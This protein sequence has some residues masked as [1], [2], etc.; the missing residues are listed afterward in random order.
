MRRVAEQLAQVLRSGSDRDAGDPH[1]RHHRL[2]GRQ[3]AELEEL[4]QHLAALGAQRA[5]LLRLFGDELQFLGGVVL[6]RVVLVG[7][8]AERLQN[9]AADAVQHDNERVQDCLNPHHDR[10]DQQRDPLGV[11]NRHRL[12][13]HL[14]EDDMEVGEHRYRDD[15]GEPVRRE[16]RRPR[17]CAHRLQDHARDG[18]LAV[19]P[20]PEARERHADLRGGDVASLAAWILQH[21]LDEARE[22]IALRGPRVDRGTRRADDGEFRRDEQR[23][24]EEQRR[25]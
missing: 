3:L 9:A 23:V 20:E 6:V 10:R 16:P 1:A 13:Q 21:A 7:A 22:P 24:H 11:L 19:H 5:L 18:M 25:R 17:R 2:A 15:A 8:D 4:L 14:A 12:G